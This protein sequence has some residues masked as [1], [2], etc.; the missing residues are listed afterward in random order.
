VINSNKIQSKLL[1]GRGLRSE[2]HL[3]DYDFFTKH[4]KKCSSVN[5]PSSP[6]KWARVSN[7]WSFFYHLF[8]GYITWY[9]VITWHE[10]R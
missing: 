3:L 5:V 1:R 9:T 7:I 2:I 8:A 4:C 6:H 10:V